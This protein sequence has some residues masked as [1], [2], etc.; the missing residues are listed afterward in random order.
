MLVLTRSISESIRIGDDIV[1]EV[2]SCGRGSVRLG[3]QA[4]RSVKIARAE[5]LEQPPAEPV[6][7]AE[8]PAPVAPPRP[9]QPALP[10]AGT[11]S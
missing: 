2:V 11:V 5:L 6:L 7:R 4:P 10:Y 1:I 8:T 3:I 9:K